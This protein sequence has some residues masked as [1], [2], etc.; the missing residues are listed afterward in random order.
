[1]PEI[2]KQAQMLVLERLKNLPRDAKL[3]AGGG[4]SVTKEELIQH[5]E[6][7]DSVGKEYIEMELFYLRSIARR[8]GSP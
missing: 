6:N 2:S 7:L 5:V 4:P 3:S 8:H 1:M